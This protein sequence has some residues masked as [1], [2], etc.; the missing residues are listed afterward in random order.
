MHSEPVEQVTIL[1]YFISVIKNPAALPGFWK[2]GG[3]AEV[4]RQE[5]DNGFHF[6]PFGQMGTGSK[7]KN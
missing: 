1:F 6:G 5:L 2:E 4:L 3:G 7:V